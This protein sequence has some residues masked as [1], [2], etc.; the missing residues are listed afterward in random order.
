MAGPLVVVEMVFKKK[1]TLQRPARTS[2]PNNFE[3][4][5]GD[6]AMIGP[7]DTMA[8]MASDDET[9][10]QL[11]VEGDEEALA[12]LMTRHRPRLRRMVMLRMDGRVRA[13][14]DPSDVVQE[15]FVEIARRIGKGT[16]DPNIPFFLW[17]RMVTGDQLARLHRTHLAFEKRNATREVGLQAI[18]LPDQSSVFLATE[19]AGQFTSADRNLRQEEV[20]DRLHQLLQSMDEKDQEIIAMRFFEELSTEEI[21]QVLGLTRSGVLKRCTRAIQR[22]SEDLGSDSIA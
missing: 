10:I 8:T 9:Q 20:R 6:W 2:V 17:M 13:R 19:L 7:V 3:R 12:D 18:G 21:A 1:L 4:F 22:L 14:F 11:A 5:T 15:A 16:F